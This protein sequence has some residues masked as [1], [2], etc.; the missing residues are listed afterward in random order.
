MS[1]WLLG[2]GVAALTGRG[3]G[4]YSREQLC[5][6]TKN[7]QRHTDP[8][9]SP[10]KRFSTHDVVFISVEFELSADDADI[11]GE[12]DDIWFSSRRRRRFNRTLFELSSDFIRI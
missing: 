10:H 4:F 12:V 3:P 6:P 9:W 11:S 2:V 8:L 7:T 1:V 5:V